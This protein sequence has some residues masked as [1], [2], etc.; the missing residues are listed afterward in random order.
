MEYSIVENNIVTNV[1]VS[2]APL[3]DNWHEGNHGIGSTYDPVTD[4]FTPPPQPDPVSHIPQVV[5]MRQARLALYGAGLLGQVNTLVSSSTPDVQIEWEFAADL[6]RDW[7]T[8][9]ALSAALGLTDE[10]VDNLFIQ[11]SQL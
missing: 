1:A 2:D 5:S 7:P 8:L 11:A 6:R 9:L 3:S 10:Q 4:T